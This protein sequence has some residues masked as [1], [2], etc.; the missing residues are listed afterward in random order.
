VYIHTPHTLAGASQI[1]LRDACV[2]PKLL[3]Y[4]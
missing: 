2:L 4:E 1:F 3:S